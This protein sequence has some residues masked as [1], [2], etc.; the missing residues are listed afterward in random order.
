MAILLCSETK[1]LKRKMKVICSLSSLLLMGLLKKKINLFPLCFLTL[2][3]IWPERKRAHWMCVRSC[4]FELHLRSQC[5]LYDYMKVRTSK[6]LLVILFKW[7]PNA[8]FFELSLS[9]KRTANNG[10]LRI[11]QKHDEKPASYFLF[12]L[13]VNHLEAIRIV[14]M[15]SLQGSN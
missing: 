12:S 4:G 10:E 1:K 3:T 11:E 7:K 8:F 9:R 2:R 6:Y 14:N 13:Q 15:N 5:A